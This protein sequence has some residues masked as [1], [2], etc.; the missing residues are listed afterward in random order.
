MNN[1]KTLAIVAVL[2]AATL[3]VGVTFAG[4][5]QHQVAFAYKKRQGWLEKTRGEIMEM[6]M[7]TQ[8]PSRQ[9]SKKLQ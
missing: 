7:V 4:Q 9:R 6:K 8:L 2:T 5:Q 1:T 3:V